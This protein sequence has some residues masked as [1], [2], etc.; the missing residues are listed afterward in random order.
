MTEK[1]L[2]QLD[3]GSVL[4]NAHEYEN[5]SLRVSNANTS[6]PPQYSRVELTY[7]ASDSVTNAKFYRGTKAEKRLIKLTGDTCGS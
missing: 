1:E 3:P 6:V 4:K 2:S 5:S 7:N